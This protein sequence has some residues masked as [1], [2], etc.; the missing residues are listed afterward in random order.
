MNM[1]Y[2][3]FFGNKYV[4]RG[5]LDFT[6]CA[7]DRYQP[8]RLW[9]NAS[10]QCIY[11]KSQCIGNG[12]I[13]HRNG[14]EESDTSCR[15]DYTRGFD[16]INKPKNASFCIPSE[17]DCSCHKKKC[18]HNGVLSPDYICTTEKDILGQNNSAYPIIEHDRLSNESITLN[19]NT[20]LEEPMTEYASSRFIVVVVTAICTSLIVLEASY[21]IRIFVVGTNSNADKIRYWR[22]LCS[23]EEL[24]SMTEDPYQLKFKTRTNH[25]DC[26]SS[27]NVID[28]LLKQLQDSSCVALLGS[29]ND[30]VNDILH[31]SALA[32]VRRNDHFIIISCETPIKIRHTYDKNSYQMFIVEDVGVREYPLQD[33]AEYMIRCDRDFK[34]MLKSGKTKIMLSFTSGVFWKTQF[35][36]NDLFFSKCITDLSLKYSCPLR[37]EQTL[38]NELKQACRKQLDDWSLN[39]KPMHNTLFSTLINNGCISSAF[40]K[41]N[42]TDQDTKKFKT[43]C[44]KYSLDSAAL[45]GDL[46]V[47]KE[48]NQYTFPD[49]SMFHFLRCYFCTRI[50]LHDFFFKFVDCNIFYERIDLETIQIEL[51]GSSMA[52]KESLEKNYFQRVLNDMS[53]KDIRVFFSKQMK[54]R[55]FRDKL[56]RYI[57]TIWGKGRVDI[58]NITELHGFSTITL[59]AVC[60]QGYTDLL[61]FML[62]YVYWAIRNRI[63]CVLL[64]ISIYQG[65][66]LSIV[67]L[68]IDEVADVNK[69]LNDLGTAPF[70]KNPVNGATLDMQIY[71]GLSALA[72]ACHTGNYEVID[73]I[74]RRKSHK[75]SQVDIRNML[76]DGAN[77]DGYNILESICKRGFA[78]VFDILFGEE[79]NIDAVDGDGNSFLMLASREGHT[80]II[81]YLLKR[82]ANVNMKNKMGWTALSM[83]CNKGATTSVKILLQNNALTNESDEGARTPLMIASQCGCMDVI[84]LLI[85]HGADKNLIDN[86]GSSALAFASKQGNIEVAEYLITENE[87]AR[88]CNNDLL[89]SMMAACQKGHIEIVRLL[90]KEGLDLNSCDNYGYTPLRISCDGS[91]DDVV[92]FLIESGADINKTGR[93]CWTALS[94]SCRNGNLSTVALLLQKGADVNKQDNYGFTPLMA[95]CQNGYY[96]IVKQLWNYNAK[97]DMEDVDGF[98]ALRIACNYGH[99]STVKF[100][101]FK[102]ANVNKVDKSG[103]SPLTSACCSVFR[104]CQQFAYKHGVP[105]KCTSVSSRSA[106]YKEIISLLIKCDADVNSIDTD[107]TTCLIA[108]S[109]G[110]HINLIKLILSKIS[111]FNMINR[112]DN[113]GKTAFFHACSRDLADVAQLLFNRGAYI[114]KSSNEGW[115]PLMIACKN[116]YKDIV[117]FLIGKGANVDIEDMYGWTALMYANQSGNEAIFQSVRQYRPDVQY[118]PLDGLTMSTTSAKRKAIFPL[119][120]ECRLAGI[121][122]GDDENVEEEDEESSIRLIVCRGSCDDI[123]FKNET[124]LSSLLVSKQDENNVRNLSSRS[125]CEYT[126]EI[127][128]DFDDALAIRQIDNLSNYSLN[129]TQKILQM[130]GTLV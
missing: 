60:S 119:P 4:L 105:G 70:G 96:N 114:N 63:A 89:N 11:K 29:E 34:Q 21:T 41:V 106:Q 53:R 101:L 36:H 31:N 94:S 26:F 13:M 78:S 57:K 65:Y 95:A 69:P 109:C 50:D 45:L 48:D 81:Q 92:D 24:P 61:A 99:T 35:S 85:L 75:V 54:N 62:P 42:E 67:Q 108:A 122:L 22:E 68:L 52:V 80:E 17:E 83:A 72:I 111:D 87:N 124:T 28:S 49:R 121:R 127:N 56:I 23:I 3:A 1:F 39:D 30:G 73:Y 12:Q 90:I 43:I 19:V 6:P 7:T 77:N 5:R 55:R 117:D 40:L 25:G 66:P 100:L 107:G 16:F 120:R 10:S 112:A 33:T 118:L 126:S 71:D 20:Y 97:I 27:K 115:T 130:E 104:D 98:T 110:G 93:D 32:F 74:V 58:S 15:C 82:A 18:P 51:S 44:R 128:L 113:N 76:L 14:T 46:P 47:L 59:I 102:G 86:K 88:L 125:L 9:S 38:T 123:A 103:C 116:G 8:I 91:H 2:D 129:M 84:Q 64:K 79:G 37:S